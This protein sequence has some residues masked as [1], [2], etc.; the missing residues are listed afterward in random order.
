MDWQRLSSFFVANKPQRFIYCIQLWW[1]CCCLREIY[2][3]YMNLDL[4]E[5]LH[6]RW[7]NIQILHNL[8]FLAYVRLPD[9][10]YTGQRHCN[11]WFFSSLVQK[12]FWCVSLHYYLIAHDLCI[13]HWLPTEGRVQQCT[14]PLH[15]AFEKIFEMSP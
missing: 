12:Y 7:Q 4:F 15:T 9:D 2:R 5:N 13:Y 6:Y 11:D 14:S 3:L 10:N 8:L 1:G